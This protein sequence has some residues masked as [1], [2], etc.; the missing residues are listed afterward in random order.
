MSDKKINKGAG[1]FP[2]WFGQV[3]GAGGGAYVGYKAGE[4]IAHSVAEH[5]HL[6]DAVAEPLEHG[7]AVA[8]AVAVAVAGITMAS[9]DP[10]QAVL[11]GATSFARAAAVAGVVA[12]GA[13]ISELRAET[14]EMHEELKHLGEG[15]V[16]GAE[17]KALDIA[18][19]DL[20]QQY[21]GS[22][23]QQGGP[24]NSGEDLVIQYLP[25]ISNHE[26]TEFGDVGA[27]SP[28]GGPNNDPDLAYDMV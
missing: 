14:K 16:H 15:G 21:M 4:G 3:A 8:G 1:T 25:N 18:H 19:A 6:P 20:Q 9:K 13:T 12:L 22:D 10:N 26:P 11:S 2:V 27:T 23:S 7:L 17:E 5:M 28:N 24:A